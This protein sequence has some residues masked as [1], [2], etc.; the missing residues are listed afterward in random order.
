MDATPP[1]LD[2]NALLQRLERLEAE[3]QSLRDENAALKRENEELRKENE[4]LRSRLA[5]SEA[6]VHELERELARRGRNRKQKSSR[7]RPEGAAD[8]RRKGE[9]KHPGATRPTPEHPTR[10]EEVRLDACP[11]CGGAVDEL[12]T[13]DERIVED[14]PEPAPEVVLYR[15]RHYRC[16]CC[17]KTVKGRADLDLPGSRI[18]PRAKLLAAFCRVGVGCSLEKTQ[19]LLDEFFGLKVSRAGVLGM[20][21]QAADLLGPAAQKLLE[22][23][24]ESGVTHADETSWPLSGRYVWCWVLCNPKL[25]VF[26]IERRRDRETFE[27]LLGGSKPGVLITDFYAVYNGMGEKQQ[28]CLAHLMVTLKELRERLPAYHQTVNIQPLIEFVGEAF[29]FARER[30]GMSEKDAAG[31]ADALRKRLREIASWHSSNPDCERIFNRLRR[32]KGELLT[33]LD[34]PAVPPDNNEAERAARGV[35]NDRGMGRGSRSEAGCGVYARLKT[36][37]ATARKNGVNF[38]RYGLEAIRKSLRNEELPLPLAQ[39]P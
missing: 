30:K 38:F 16:Q 10:C 29:A 8:R 32:H 22:L 23:L 3:V 31:K 39:P 19:I 21:E 36:V 14:V 1:S 17:R 24:R 34:D 9:R 5:A 35:A 18:G 6:R 20:V 13:F 2:V 37:F 26:L 15:R 25:A 33:F 11:L 28:R 27:R 7:R 4:D 12:A